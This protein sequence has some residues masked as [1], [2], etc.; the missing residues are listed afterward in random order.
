M[1]KAMLRMYQKQLRE[2]SV[3]KWCL[4]T[5]LPASATHG[6]RGARMLEDAGNLLLLLKLSHR[7]SGTVTVS[8]TEQ[9]AMEH[10]LT[11]SWPAAHA[12]L[13]WCLWGSKN[14]L[15][16]PHFAVPWREASLY[17]GCSA[18]LKKLGKHIHRHTLFSSARAYGC[19]KSNRC[20]ALFSFAW[21]ELQGQNWGVQLVFTS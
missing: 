21:K 3:L 19:F 15:S 8:V 6:H 7:S 9:H 1:V 17:Y 20:D 16:N 2:S 4:C 13:G 10:L 12:A 18:L 11:V 14:L 5:S